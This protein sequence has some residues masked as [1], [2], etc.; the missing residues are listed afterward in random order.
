MKI[1]VIKKTFGV[2]SKN[3]PYWMNQRTYNCYKQHVEWLRANK[4]S[5][6]ELMRLEQWLN[7]EYTKLMNY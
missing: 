5:K 1:Q 3:K 2:I 6:A 4:A 7:D